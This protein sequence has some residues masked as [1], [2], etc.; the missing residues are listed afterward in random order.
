M[1]MIGFIEMQPTTNFYNIAITQSIFIRM[2]YKLIE[3]LQKLMNLLVWLEH[4]VY[5]QYATIVLFLYVFDIK[6]YAAII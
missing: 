2:Q 1:R 4:C 3:K 6:C 5:I